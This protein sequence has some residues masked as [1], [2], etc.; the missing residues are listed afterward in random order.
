MS[1]FTIYDK[2]ISSIMDV[3]VSL[4]DF[5]EA[6]KNLSVKKVEGS[7]P[8][9]KTDEEI[10]EFLGIDLSK[11]YCKEV[12]INNASCEGYVDI[13]VDED[14]IPYFESAEEQLDMANER[15]HKYEQF[16]NNWSERL[17]RWYYE[18]G[19]R[20]ENSEI[21]KIIKEL[22]GDKSSI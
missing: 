18:Q 7:E 4:D 6:I 16:V 22:I 9:F 15:C 21:S 2:W 3:R 5:V 17:E 10:E 19:G 14:E 20:S 1:E 11:S 12:D 8:I 13:D